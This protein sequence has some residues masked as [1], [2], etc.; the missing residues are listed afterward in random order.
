LEDAAEFSAVEPYDTLEISKMT[1]M[2][3]KLP[4]PDNE[5]FYR[6]FI[7]G[8]NITF[9]S[10]KLK[11]TKENTYKRIARGRGKLS[12]VLKEEGYDV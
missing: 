3:N 2:L 4:P 6:H 1:D 11:I 9:I 5:I 8:E 7:L 12:R 10:E